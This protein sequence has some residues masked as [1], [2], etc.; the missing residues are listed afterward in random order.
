[1]RQLQPYGPTYIFMAK[2]GEGRIICDIKKKWK[3]FLLKSS[4][5][6]GSIAEGKAVKGNL[7]GIGGRYNSSFFRIS[8]SF[9][10]KVLYKW[11]YMG[12]RNEN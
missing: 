9:L 4:L 1:M 8:S 3:T 2:L 11:T 10:P 12:H 6:C 7:L 5:H